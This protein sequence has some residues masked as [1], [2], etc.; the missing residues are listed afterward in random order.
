MLPLPPAP[1][2]GT[3][4]DLHHHRSCRGLHTS[5]LDT[6]PDLVHHH[7]SIHGAGSWAAMLMPPAVSVR[8]VSSGRSCIG[9]KAVSPKKKYPLTPLVAAIRRRPDLDGCLLE[10]KLPRGCGNLA[11]SVST[12]SASI[13]YSIHQ[14]RIGDCDYDLHFPPSRLTH[15]MALAPSSSSTSPAFPLRTAAHVPLLRPRRQPLRPSPNQRPPRTLPPPRLRLVLA[16]TIL[17]PDAF[18]K[19][20][21]PSLASAACMPAPSGGACPSVEAVSG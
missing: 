18:G 10:A 6:L 17:P 1:A 21:K 3:P 19:R 13:Q 9:R 16:T 14:V 11:F 20:Q 12:Q 8:A 15:A 7:W 4:P 2:A 5:S